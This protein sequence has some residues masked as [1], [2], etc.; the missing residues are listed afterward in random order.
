[1]PSYVTPKKNTAFVFNLPLAD[2]TV[3]TA[4]KANPTLAAGD[5]KISIDGG[6]FNNITSLPTVSPASGRI[7]Q[8]SLSS[9]EMNGDN[10]AVQFVDQTTPAEWAEVE[11]LIQTSARQIDDL[12]FPNTS[13]RGMDIDASG[14]VEVGSFQ[15]GAITT[16]AFT[17]GAINAAAIAPDAIGASGPDAHAASETG[18]ADWAAA[19]SIR[20]AWGEDTTTLD[21]DATIRS[22]VGLASANLDTQIADLP[23]ANENADALLDRSAGVETG[24]TFRQWLRLAASTL[25]GKA[26]G[27]ETTTAIFRDFGDTK[28]R[29]TAT[30]DANGN[31]T[32]V[33]RD[34]T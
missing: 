25:F 20:P 14:G 3:A 22:A 19:A 34:A 10:I 33:T 21:L 16:A 15:T 28:D 13:G 12:A 18:T 1:M 8:V 5:V 2:A 7:V 26:S 23:T 11:V 9:S 6:A 29:I 27:L 31:R 4:F 32:A 24:L 17:A 30:V